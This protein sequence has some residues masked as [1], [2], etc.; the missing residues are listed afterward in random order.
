MKRFLGHASKRRLAGRAAFLRWAAPVILFVGWLAGYTATLT[1]VHTF[2]ALSYVLDVDHKPWYALFHPHHLAYGP[3]GVVIRNLAHI[4]GW[5]DSARVPLQLVNACAGALG[6]AFFFI[7]IHSLTKRIDLACC[8]ALLTGANYAYWY[9]AVEVEV[10]TIAA[11]FLLI[12]L[13][14]LARLLECPTPRV[15]AAL[16]LAQSLAILFHQTNVLLC[17]P[18][19]IALCLSTHN[20]ITPDSQPQ[21]P[22]RRSQFLMLSL[23]YALPLLLIVGGSYLVIGV[24]VSGFRSWEQLL[25]WMLAYAHTGWWGGTITSEKWSDLGAGLAGT[26]AQPGGAALG[27]LLVGL[28]VLYLRHLLVRTSRRL[29][30]CLMLWLLTYGC[31]FFWWEPDNIEF[32]IASVP[33]AV[34]LLILALDAAGPRWHPGVWIALAVGVTM[35]GVNYD[36]ITRRGTVAYDL[37]RRVTNALANQ[38]MPGD[39]FLVPDGMQEL[40]LPYYAGRYNTFSLNRALFERDGNWPAA[41]TLVRERIDATLSYGFAVLV[42]DEVLYPGRVPGVASILDRFDLSSEQVTVCFTPYLADLVPVKLP[43]ELS[44]LYRLPAV[45]ELA[46]DHGWNFARH[47]WGWQARNSADA[48]FAAGWEF[49]PGTDAQVISPPMR[50]DASQ[51]RAIE[52]QMATTTAA[53]DAQFFFMDETEHTTEAHS[54]RWTLEPGSD[55]VTYR[56]ELAGQPGWSGVITRLRLDPVGVGDGGRVRIESIRLIQAED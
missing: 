17:L 51:Y 52:I 38:G 36:A 27:L 30:L 20:C 25:D 48:R 55:V 31:F 39:L 43:D 41:C 34:L 56:L 1:Q 35:F 24:G 32:W 53:R 8:G 44:I 42:D 18:I 14:F 47:G 28:L 6:I 33:P 19:M 15:S 13:W 54:I 45:Q 37:Q 9:Y 46:E 7:L 29:V 49:I 26:V 21:K 23:A 5:S 22:S 50:L 11:L 10:Y 2:D 12:C 3:F 16:G 40:Y 4:T